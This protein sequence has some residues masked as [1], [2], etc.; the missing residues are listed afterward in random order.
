[1]GHG[2]RVSGTAAQTGPLLRRRHMK[3]GRQVRLLNPEPDPRPPEHC[4]KAGCP[5]AARPF[6]DHTSPTERQGH[7]PRSSLQEI[8][9]DVPITTEQ[10]NHL[11]ARGDSAITVD[12]RLTLVARRGARRVNTFGIVDML[13]EF[14]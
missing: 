9:L 14:A 4:I 7:L 13:V 10:S 12:C 1:M 2:A 8:G 11:R 3:K 6:A 5:G